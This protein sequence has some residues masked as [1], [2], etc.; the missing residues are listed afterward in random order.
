MAAADVFIGLEPYVHYFIGSEEVELGS[1]Y[2]YDILLEP[3][4]QG[5]MTCNER[6]ARHIVSAYEE[7]YTKIMPELT[8]SAVDL[9]GIALL[10]RNIDEVAQTLIWGLE[11]QKNKSVKEAIRLSK[12]KNSCTRFKEPTYI[13]LG[14]FYA[15][16]L[17]NSAQCE[18]TDQTSEFKQ[19]I[20]RLLKEGHEIIRQVVI[21]NAVGDKMKKATGIAICF[22]EFVIHKSYHHNPFATKTQWL[23][24]LKKYLGS[25]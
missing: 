25:H 6:F 22:P 16:L 14:H 7:A 15:N 1:G 20:T 10:E 21:A 8:H 24:F 2:K 11:R 13:D 4:L 18:L 5:T 19:R 3:L 23:K 12:H 9:T 17:N